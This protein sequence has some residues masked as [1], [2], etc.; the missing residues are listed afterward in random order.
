MLFHHVL[1]Q[2]KR[3]ADDTDRRQFMKALASF[4]ARAPYA[5][6]PVEVRGS[7]IDAD[8]AHGLLVS[9]AACSIHGE[10]PRTADASISV[11]FAS[12]D[13]FGQYLASDAHTALLRD[14]VEP[15]CDA[16]WSVQFETAAPETLNSS[17]AGEMTR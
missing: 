5:V 17:G 7:G 6:G 2:L 3:P 8:R 16:W 10:P 11:T 13:D 14:A 1:F 15:L 12:R 4:A 9:G